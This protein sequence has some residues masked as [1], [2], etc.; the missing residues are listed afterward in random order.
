MADLS[1][2]NFAGVKLGIVSD[3]ALAKKLAREIQV[4]HFA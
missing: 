2:K 4:S 1:V 3:I